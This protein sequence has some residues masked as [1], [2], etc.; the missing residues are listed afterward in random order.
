MKLYLD[1]CK[2]RK[3]AASNFL[4]NVKTAFFAQIN[5]SKRIKSL[6]IVIDVP[7]LIALLCTSISKNSLIL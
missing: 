7:F 6:N 5:Q 1:R 4:K 2:M 3:N